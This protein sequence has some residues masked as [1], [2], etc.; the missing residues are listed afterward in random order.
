MNRK[1]I[2]NSKTRLLLIAFGMV[3]FV[4][5]P[6]KATAQEVMYCDDIG[7]NGFHFNKKSSSYEYSKVVK[8]R[9]KIQVKKSGENWTF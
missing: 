9:Y 3:V 5:I 1:L 4:A 2:K 7:A 8:E 6:H